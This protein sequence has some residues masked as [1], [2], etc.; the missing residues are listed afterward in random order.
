MVNTQQCVHWVMDVLGQ[1]QSTQEAIVTLS[2]IL[3]NSYTSL[4]LSSLRR[5]SIT[6]WTH[7]DC[8]PFFQMQYQG[9]LPTGVDN[10]RSFKRE[11]ILFIWLTL[12]LIALGQHLLWIIHDQALKCISREK[13]LFWK[14]LVWLL[15]SRVVLF[16]FKRGL[17]YSEKWTFKLSICK[18]DDVNSRMWYIWNHNLWQVLWSWITLKCT[19]P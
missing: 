12:H 8:W 19:N 11:G 16:F 17:L 9:H 18:W 5:A 7:A 4:V 6:Q 15:W 1:L 2:Y 13:I 14:S 3:C 10:L